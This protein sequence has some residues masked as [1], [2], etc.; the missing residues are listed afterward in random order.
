MCNLTLLRGVLKSI[1]SGLECLNGTMKYIGKY[2]IADIMAS[3]Y[4]PDAVLT[5]ER[6]NKSEIWDAQTRIKVITELDKNRQKV[7]AE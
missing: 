1:A 4:Q 3:S 5:I 2:L 7:P 6:H